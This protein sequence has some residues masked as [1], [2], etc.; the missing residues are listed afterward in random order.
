[1]NRTLVFFLGFIAGIAS[2]ILALL[3][4]SS[5][6]IASRLPKVDVVQE[7]NIEQ[8]SPKRLSV[9]YVDV[10]GKKGE[11]TV[12]TFM[13]KDSVKLLIGKPTKTD[14]N[15]IGSRSQETWTYEFPGQGVYGTLRILK[16]EFINGE[17]RNISEY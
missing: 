4:I 6:S 8:I 11:V 15:T 12:H 3:V 14:L 13:P 7:D 10:R 16:I 9:Q 17:L 2:V 1:M 5:L